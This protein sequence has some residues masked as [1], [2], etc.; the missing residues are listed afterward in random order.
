MVSLFVSGSLE[1]FCN[2]PIILPLQL[3]ASMRKCLIC[4]SYLPGERGTIETIVFLTDM[5]ALDTL[6]FR[7]SFLGI[8]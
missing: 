4:H 5:L 8:L 7:Q 3:V 2:I 6:V 1:V